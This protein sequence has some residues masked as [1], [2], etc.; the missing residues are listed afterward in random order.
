MFARVCKRYCALCSNDNLIARA[1]RGALT[2]AGV[3]YR[4]DSVT[5]LLH[6]GHRAYY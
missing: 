3:G 4:L 1:G 2:L 6:R 5:R